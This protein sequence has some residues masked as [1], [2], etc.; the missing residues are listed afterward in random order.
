MQI[1]L[2]DSL[3]AWAPIGVVVLGVGIM[4]VCVT[5][6]LF[7]QRRRRQRSPLTRGL[8]RGPG[9][10]LQNVLDDLSMNMTAFFFV[11][12]AGPIVVFSIH[13]SLSY[14]AGIPETRFRIVFGT[15]LAAGICIYC[16]VRV[17]KHAARVRQYQLELECELAVGQELNSLQAHGFQ[18]FHD[19]PTDKLNIDHVIVGPTGVFAVETR[20]RSKP[21]HGKGKEDARVVFDGKSLK[22]PAWTE[23]EPVKQ[24]RRQ[25]QWLHNW[26]TQAVGVSVDVMPAIALPGWFVERISR[27]DML[28]FNGT[29]PDNIFPNYGAR[30]Y[31]N[32]MI[33]QIAHQLDR[34]CRDVETKSGRHTK[35]VDQKFGK[36]LI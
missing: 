28:I 2:P 36:A 14:L 18:V 1:E 20:G 16:V 27:A 7:L 22:F 23:Q 29:Q 13:L 26:L 3:N 35:A 30:R 24:T 31:D 8:L 10:S 33:E 4:Y 11:A 12:W 15:V 6:W 21:V 17:L 25:A 19:L 9:E 34:Y 32:S 5:E